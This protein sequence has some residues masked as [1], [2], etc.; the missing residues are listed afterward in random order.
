MGAYAPSEEARMSDQPTIYVP[1]L[2]HSHQRE[3]F[4]RLGISKFG[5]WR[6]TMTVVNIRLF[7]VASA[8][9]KVQQRCAPAEDGTSDVRDLSLV[10]AEIGC[11]ACFD[12]KAFNEAVQ[13]VY[14][15]GLSHLAQLTRDPKS[16]EELRDQAEGQE[17]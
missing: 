12:R 17:S 2:C 9:P 1:N 11:L 6:A 8:N 7:Q 13:I 5:P 16:V 15:H 14:K 3:L 4:N 10:L